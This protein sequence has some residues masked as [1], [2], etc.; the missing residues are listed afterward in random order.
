MG[1]RIS[2]LPERV[3][4]GGMG[5]A[6]AV[7]A[8]VTAKV[9]IVGATTVSSLVGFPLDQRTILR[10]VVTTVLKQGLAFFGIAFLYLKFRDRPL[11]SLPIKRPNH[12]HVIWTVVGVIAMFALALLLAIVVNHMG[13]EMGQNKIQRLGAQEP[14]LYLYLIPMAF[15]LVGPGEELVF[16]GIIQDRLRETFSAT[17]AIVV[18]SM[19]F[20]GAHVLA[21]SGSITAILGSMSI[22]FLVSLILGVIFEKTDNLLVVVLIHS[23]YDAILFSISYF[24]AKS[25]QL[26]LAFV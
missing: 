21:L 16:R 12:W 8:L 25:G 24:L 22:L 7:A 2:S 18:A 11:S 19:I 26:G 4:T 9:L 1:E 10:T 5:L 14:R 15:L 17:G 6:V 3:R 20:A 13:I 23:L